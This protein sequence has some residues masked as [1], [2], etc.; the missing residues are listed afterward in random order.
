ML[1]KIWPSLLRFISKPHWFQWFWLVIGFF[2]TLWF[3][4]RV[5]PKPSR[6]AYPCQ[7][8]AFPLTSG[9]VVW[10]TGVIISALAFRK[11]KKAFAHACYVAGFLCILTSILAAWI[12][13]T[14]LEQKTSL[15]ADPVP[16]API[17]TPQG[18]HP[19]RVVWVH[20][21]S[22]TYWEG[23][24]SGDGYPWQPEHTKQFFVNE[25][26]SQAIRNLAGEST[27]PNA[28]DRLF[29]YFNIEHGRDDRG[30]LAGEKITIK[31]NLVTC[32]YFLE[33]INPET[34]DKISY[35]DKADTMPQMIVALLRQL[36]LMAGANESDISVG[37]TLC[38]FPNQW[39]NIIHAEFPEVQ[40]FDQ[41][42]SFGRN[43]AEPS[44]VIQHWSH[45]QGG[46]FLA[47]YIPRCYAEADYLI[48]FAVLKGH[49]AGITLCAK[50]HYGSYIR[51]PVAQ[52]YY[53]LHES[54]A[55]DN[56]NPNPA[57]YRA[58]VD[59]MGHPQMGG[60][61]LLYLID[62]LYGGYLSEGTPHKFQMAPFN[63]D[64]PSS[65]FASQDPVA[66]DS[67]GLDFLWEESSIETSEWHSNY[68]GNEVVKV[69][70]VDD[71][72]HEAALAD[73]PPSGT[74]YDPNG[75]GIGLQSLGVH[76]RWNNPTDMQYTQIELIKVEVIE[77]SPDFNQ[78]GIVDI[79]DLDHLFNSWLDTTCDESNDWCD[80][81]D[82]NRSGE[83]NIVD[84]LHLS[85]YWLGST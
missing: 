62:G 76:E 51:T 20:D 34:Y 69:G 50:N 47:D 60:K 37:D 66:I 48:N 73:N 11:A 84:F 46:S 16:N 68:V 41:M 42:G 56:F 36:V 75:D 52:G 53:Q 23:P 3:L 5:L 8:I 28:W 9:F 4:I 18:L 2:S 40:C 70:G 80:K 59:I 19:G 13:L 31:V 33:S 35:L 67:V 21:Q 22:A 54:I 64:W 44:S 55:G 32:I 78:D 63:N 85:K 72:L 65:L 83:V 25:L 29:R 7:R 38:Y 49:P 43:R 27:D 26:M 79:L 10:L 81:A 30:Y 1:R 57:Q 77:H 17:G 61:T 82:C 74:F 45:G 15:A 58:L 14:H 71:Y 12:A 24:D 39:W 6:A